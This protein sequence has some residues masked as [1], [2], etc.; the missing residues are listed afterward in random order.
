MRAKDAGA[1]GV[2]GGSGNVLNDGGRAALKEFLRR[3]A[4]RVP[5]RP[6]DHLL[7]F[8]RLE[9]GG[10]GGDGGG[11]GGEGG[12]GGAPRLAPVAW[13]AA[14]TA[15]AK[16][17]AGKREARFRARV[18]R[19][20]LARRATPSLPRS[21][22]ARQVID[23]AADAALAAARVV[24][25]ATDAAGHER[26]LSHFYNFLWWANASDARGSMR[27]DDGGAAAA[28]RRRRALTRT[29]P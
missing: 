17:F 27:C 7:A 1:G 14:T 19:A 26:Y 16:R 11:G 12:G 10:D 28:R 9:R 6:K 23:V 22:P 29:R 18:A 20:S 15:A 21:A 8:G 25:F 2:Y 13:D 4:H 3:R 5:W 24:H